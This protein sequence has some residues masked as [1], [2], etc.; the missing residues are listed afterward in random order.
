MF[1]I[2]KTITLSDFL[3]TKDS[4]YWNGLCKFKVILYVLIHGSL[5]QLI[6]YG[7]FHTVLD[8]YS[9]FINDT[10]GLIYDHLMYDFFIGLYGNKP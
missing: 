2:I 6:A 10:R 1:F 5:K 4:E 9:Y 8:Y 3:E 7:F